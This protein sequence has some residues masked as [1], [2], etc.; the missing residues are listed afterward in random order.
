MRKLLVALAIIAALIILF[1]LAK[2]F[3]APNIEAD[4]EER[5]SAA[6]GQHQLSH[7]LQRVDGR[8]VY[9]AGHLANASD[10]EK[11]TQVIKDIN[12]V[13]VVNTDI[14]IG[15]YNI[16]ADSNEGDAH[17][18]DHHTADMADPSELEAN[19]EYDNEII[20]HHGADMADAE[21]LA[22]NANIRTPV[23]NLA[24]SNN[25][26]SITGDTANPDALLS[27]FTQNKADSELTTIDTL[28]NDW[29]Q[30][31]ETLASQ[32]QY[33]ENAEI[34]IDGEQ[35]T[36]RGDLIDMNKSSD[37]QKA[38]R[39]AGAGIYTLSYDV[40]QANLSDDSRQCQSQLTQIMSN[41]SIL[42]SSSSAIISQDSQL[43]LD[44]LANTLNAC[45]DTKVNIAGHTDSQ[46]NEALNQNLSEQRAKAVQTALQQRG[47]A[48]TAL[49]T[50]GAGESKPIATNE[51]RE[52]R[53]LN[54]RI[55]LTVTQ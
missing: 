15:E 23:F 53:A 46:G 37:I 51:T 45:P 1:L 35:V 21:E 9:L 31:T 20:D 52:G 40:A 50:T 6:L 54:R 43:L 4:I 48:A 2:C 41:E 24:I 12:G 11:I 13:R 3:F 8:D 36:I 44:S 10:A 25:E 34:S 29:T 49:S 22:A 42:F 14:H 27:K 30:L 5:V 32:S 39:A 33:F 17:E 19:R 26:Y 55:S 47:V 18:P 28:S 38:V 16:S 7:L